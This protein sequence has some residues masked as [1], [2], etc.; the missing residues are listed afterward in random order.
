M[1][2][3]PRPFLSADRNGAVLTLKLDRPE[4]RN[5]LTSEQAVDELVAAFAAASADESV[6]VVILTAAG[7]VFSSGGD[8]NEMRAFASGEV[9]LREIRQWYRQRIHRMVNAVYNADVPIIAAIN[10]PAVG[11]GC[12]LACMCDMRV[13]AES[14]TFAE[15]FVRVGL[16]SGDGGAWILPRVVGQAKAMEMTFTGDPIDAQEALRCG[17]VSRVVAAEDLLAAA[18]SLAA[19][20][21]KNSGTTLRMAKRL[22][23]QAEQ[24]NLESTLELSAALQAVAHRSAEHREALAAF[25]EKRT[26]EFGRR[27]D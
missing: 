3:R 18:H 8:L 26:P 25:F 4:S 24:M 11:A 22:M 16:I 14:A 20:I 17:L 19:R 12:D 15:S 7:T 23:R 13:A 10:G 9:G 27:P 2:S 6:A 1:T 5:A 21:A